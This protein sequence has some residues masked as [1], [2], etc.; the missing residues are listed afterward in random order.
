M[1]SQRY[2]SRC[3]STSVRSLKHRSGVSPT[4]KFKGKQATSLTSSV[5]L[6]LALVKVF[7][8]KIPPRACRYGDKETKSRESASAGSLRSCKVPALDYL[9]AVL[10]LPV[11]PQSDTA[12]ELHMQRVKSHPAAVITLSPCFQCV[13]RVL[14]HTP[15]VTLQPG[16]ST[17]CPA[18]SRSIVLSPFHRSPGC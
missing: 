2:G 4:V 14:P 3:S 17:A 15:A 18:P 12:G 16:M 8:W 6:E 11:L 1:V 13:Q 7:I 9:E 10:A 5:E